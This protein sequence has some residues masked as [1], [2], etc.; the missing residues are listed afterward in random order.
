MEEKMNKDIIK[1]IIPKKLPNKS[2]TCQ[3]NNT[4][5]S[6]SQLNLKN[7]IKKIFASAVL[8]IRT[9]AAQAQTS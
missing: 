1:L 3:I 8:I 4:L 9:N 6:Q 5:A 7:M 2:C